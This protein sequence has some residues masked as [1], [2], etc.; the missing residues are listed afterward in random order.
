MKKL[1]I[2]IVAAAI[3]LHFNPQPKLEKWFNEQKTIALTAYSKATDTKVRLKA[4]KIYQDIE[5]KLTQFNNEE[6]E[7]LKEL[8]DSRDSVVAFYQKYCE[9]QRITP[10]FHK[11]N[12]NLVCETMS[13]YQSFFFLPSY[14]YY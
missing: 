5:P 12:Q 11:K 4:S 1:L 3:F 14:C 2:L 8:T 10:K 7:Y 9:T 6:K 13:R